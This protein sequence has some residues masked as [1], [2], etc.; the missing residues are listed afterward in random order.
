[1]QVRTN[2]ESGIPEAQ[3]LP[4]YRDYFFPAIRNA[5]RALD[6]RTWLQSEAMMDAARQVGVPT[7]VSTKYWSEHIGRPYQ[8]PETHEFFGYQALLEKPRPHELFWEIWGLG[9]HRILLWGNPDFT[10]RIVSTVTVSHTLGFEVDAPPT[11]KGYGNRPGRWDVFTDAQSAR[12]FWHWDFERYW[13]FYMLWGRLSYDPS[14]PEAVWMHEMQL[15]FGAAAPD[16][17]EAYRQSSRVLHEIVAVH[18][19]DPNMY[20]WPEINPGGLIDSYKE[21]LPSDWRYIA[22]IP[23]AVQN[24]RSGTPSAKQT[25]LD[26]AAFFD[27]VAGRIDA[28][29]KRASATLGAGNREWNGS[30]PDFQVLAS[31]ARYHA[32]KQRAALN[33][34]WFDVTGN[35]DALATAKRSLMA[36][37][38]RMGAAR[39]VHRWPVLPEFRERTG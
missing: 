32:H 34:E 27:D 18:L 30:S 37:Q 25:A 35:A 7:R 13:L 11:Q 1:M 19:A 38:D 21:V 15:R 33:L 16:V 10:R 4:F 17:F 31:L 20:I 3:Q 26:T 12:K 39:R 23:E 24:L 36:G 22:S 5:G 29:V 9:S 14:T 6:L 8:P 28:A 2:A